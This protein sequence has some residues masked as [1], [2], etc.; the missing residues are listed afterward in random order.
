M[1]DEL[2]RQAA[3]AGFEVVCVDA[4]DGSTVLTA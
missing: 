1:W 4:I 2:V 3:T